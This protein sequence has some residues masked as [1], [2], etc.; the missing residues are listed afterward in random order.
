MITLLKCGLYELRLIEHEHVTLHA[1]MT[2][3]IIEQ[4]E[5]ELCLK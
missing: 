1:S 3:A 5:I 4:L 2:E